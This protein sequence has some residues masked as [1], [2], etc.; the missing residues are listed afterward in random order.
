MGV[1]RSVEL[2]DCPGVVLLREQSKRIGSVEI[3]R[4]VRPVI[5]RDDHKLSLS[6]GQ[7]RTSPLVDVS[8]DGT[9]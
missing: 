8:A 3:R 5:P 1:S 7:T 2:A 4:Q 9:Q 6:R